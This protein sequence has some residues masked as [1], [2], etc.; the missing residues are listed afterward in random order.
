MKVLEALHFL[1]KGVEDM[2]LPQISVGSLN[3]QH[4]KNS[5][6]NTVK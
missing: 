1:F 2:Q 3:V 6:E 5:T 4:I